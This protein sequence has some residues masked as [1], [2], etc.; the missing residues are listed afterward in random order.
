MLPAQQVED[1]GY[2]KDNPHK[3]VEVE[4]HLP[5][6]LQ[7]AD[8]QVD[9]MDLGAGAHLTAGRRVS[10]P[11]EEHL[12]ASAQLQ[13]VVLHAGRPPDVPVHEHSRLPRL[14]RLAHL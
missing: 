4:G 3:G 7:V 14:A 8:L 12:V 1:L 10:V 9:E 13:R 5:E 11:H 2:L 6:E